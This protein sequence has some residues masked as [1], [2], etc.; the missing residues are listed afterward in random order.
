MKLHHLQEAIISGT[1]EPAIIEVPKPNVDMAQAEAVKPDVYSAALLVEG[2]T[3]NT[4][5]VENGVRNAQSP[6][7]VT[8]RGGWR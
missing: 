6:M 3:E 8:A 1:P 4:A 5:R 7:Y 2:L